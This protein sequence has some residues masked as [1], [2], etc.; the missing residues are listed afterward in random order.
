MTTQSRASRS[1]ASQ[2]AA[3]QPGASFLTTWFAILD[4]EDADRILDLISDDFSFSILF[5]TGGDG[6]TDFHGGRAEMEGYLAQRE[7]G[8]RTHHLLSASTVGRD[9]LFLGE[10]RRHGEPEATFVASARLTDTG[11]VRRLLIG[12]SPSVLFS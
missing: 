2:P 5:S 10:V 6:A 8:V 12:R 11:R 9:E 4:S 3:S 1:A 7:V